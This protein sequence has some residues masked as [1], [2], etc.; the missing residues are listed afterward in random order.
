MEKKKL[1]SAILKLARKLLSL[2]QRRSFRVTLA[3]I[4]PWGSTILLKFTARI[5]GGHFYTSQCHEH[6][7]KLWN[8]KLTVLEIGVGG[9]EDPNYGG[10]SLRMWKKY[11]RQS[12]IYGLDIYDKSARQEKRIKIFQGN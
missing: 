11:F 3:H 12:M 5:S 6:F 7:Q 4:Y 9:Y 8:N 1:L 10:A 2:Q